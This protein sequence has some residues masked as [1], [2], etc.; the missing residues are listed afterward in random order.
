MAESIAAGMKAGQAKIIVTLKT[1]S[2]LSNDNLD[3]F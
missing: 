3:G 1:V 2:E